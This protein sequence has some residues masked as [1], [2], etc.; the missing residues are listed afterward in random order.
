LQKSP[1]ILRSLLIGATPIHWRLVEMF[2]RSDTLTT[3]TSYSEV[4]FAKETYKR[5][6]ILQK[7]PIISRSLLIG[8][9]PIHWRLVEMF[10]R[11]DTLTTD[12]RLVISP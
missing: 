4:F 1:I 8:A 5:D 3:D 7:S 11:S 6:H 12:L 2:L 10:L 9:T